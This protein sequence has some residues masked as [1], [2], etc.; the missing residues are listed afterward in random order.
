MDG[1]MQ[2]TIPHP[3]IGVRART[4]QQS[5]VRA[6]QIVLSVHLFLITLQFPIRA[7]TIDT[8]FFR[9]I[10]LLSAL[11]IWAITLVTD[12]RHTKQP[13]SWLDKLFVLYVSYGII[14]IVTTLVNGLSMLEALTQFRNFFLPA[15]LYF[16]AKKAFGS[17]RGQSVIIGVFIVINLLL[18]TDVIGEYL[19]Q[20]SGYQ[21]S[22]IPWYPYMFRTGDRFIG[23][24]V[25]TVGSILPEDTPILGL[26]GYPHYTVAP[27]M[28]TFAFVYPFLVEKKLKEFAEGIAF[29][30][31]SVPVRVRQVLALLAILAV[32]VLGVRTHLISIILIMMIL[33][34]FFDRRLLIRNLLIILAAALVFLSIGFFD[35]IYIQ[36]IQSGFFSSGSR[37]STISYVLSVRELLFIVNSPVQRL[38]FGNADVYS[39]V[40]TEVGTFEL[41]LLFFAAAFGVIWLSLFTA[42]FA[43][44]FI[45]ARRIVKT[46]SL[47]QLSRVY[48]IGSIGLLFVYLLDAGH[49]AR[50][51]WAP[52]IDIWVICLGALSAIVAQIPKKSRKKVTSK[53]L[54]QQR[55]MCAN[56]AG[57][58]SGVRS[59]TPRM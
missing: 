36:N 4:A 3:L 14:T 17:V 33:P 51:M 18:I 45:Y 8:T 27:L 23:N 39:Q 20:Q 41:R 10:L 46:T 7:F 38:L 15:A 58:A 16:P 35:P 57:Q 19:V 31:A 5:G 47:P 43:T 29:A 54:H 53:I 59:A 48:G 40:F 6:L 55:T 13:L 2:V 44:G 28:A 50:T 34:F 37:D 30:L 42:I 12:K 56:P 11:V 49:Y 32:L 9:D 22:V 52:N 26:L 21:L 1:M 24:Q 25:G